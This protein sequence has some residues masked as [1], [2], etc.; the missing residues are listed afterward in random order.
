MARRCLAVATGLLLDRLVGDP[1]DR[2]HPVA[3]FGTAMT[4]LE[5]ALWADDRRRGV[6][7]AVVGVGLGALTGATVG[8]TT[9]A[10]AVSAAG[11]GLRATATH[12]GELV[13]IGDLAAARVELPALVGRD[14]SALD[15]A[16]VCA[17][18][19]ESV[20]ENTVDAVVAPAWWAL[21]GGAPGALA[22]RA[23]NTMD[24]MVG[25]RS[26]RHLRYGWAAARL[27]DTANWAPARITAALVAVAASRR[28]RAVVA[29]VRRDAGA[30]PSPNAGV[31]EAAM[32]GALGRRLG[33][34]L[35]YGAR[36]EQRPFLGDGPPPDAGDVAA[37]VAVAERVETLCVVALV[38]GAALAATGR[39][40]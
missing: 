16:G 25:H 19:V 6:I 1:P 11:R 27:D 38:A 9:V 30:H 21:L 34:P 36:Q 3:W 13:E 39:R 20:A 5:G 31:A 10:V 23:V 15:A 33:G 24:A 35:R 18:V 7:H 26:E 29:T 14:P 8:S 28:A 37:A 40:R 2:W 22:Y 17:A 12:V 4:A 32:A